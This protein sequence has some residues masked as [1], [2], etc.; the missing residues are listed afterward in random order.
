VR[1]KDWFNRHHVKPA[2]A[3]TASRF[4]QRPDRG[5]NGF[6]L[7]EAEPGR[8]RLRYID[9]RR[10]ERCTVDLPVRNGRLDWAQKVS[11]ACERYAG[12]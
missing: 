6:C 1:S 8:L 10:N 9:W 3:E 5:N 2:W 7:L 4:E 12:H 11:E